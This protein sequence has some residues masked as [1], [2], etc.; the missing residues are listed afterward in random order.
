MKNWNKEMKSEFGTIHQNSEELL[1]RIHGNSGFPNSNDEELNYICHL[2]RSQVSL[3]LKVEELMLAKKEAEKNASEKYAELFQ[4]APVAYLTL[5]R[6]GKIIELNT[7]ASHLL[8]IECTPLR[9]IHFESFVDDDTKP[10]FNQ[11]LHRVLN[12]NSIEV[13]EVTILKKGSLPQFIRLT[14]K[15]S[16]NA[17]QYL[18]TAINIAELKRADEALIEADWRF[19]ALFENSPIAV[20]YH[21]MIYD[22]YRK[23]VDYRFLDANKSYRELTGTDPRG[24]TVKQAFPDIENGVFDW[25]GT[26]G[27]VVNTGKTIRF[28]Q[29]LQY[30][31]R[32]YDCVAYTYKPNHFVTSFLEITKR[33]SAEVALKESELK[34]RTVADQTSDWVYWIGEDQQIFYMSPAC[35]KITG[36]DPE[37]FLSKPQL[38]KEIVYSGDYDSI[39][40]YKNQ[41]LLKENRDKVYDLEIRVVSKEGALVW[42]HHI[43]S[44]IFNENGKYLGR[45]IS[46]RDITEK[47]K[48]ITDL[49]KAKERAEESDR[50]MSSFLANMSHEIRTPMTGI[51]GFTELLKE[52]NL[53]VKEQME[54]IRIIE[55]SGTRMLNII[56]DIMSISKVESG[57]MEVYLSE[58]NINTQIDY[59]YTFFKPEAEK[60][61][62]QLFFKKTLS[63]QEAILKTDKEKIYSILTNLVKNAIKF[64]PS[65]SIEFGYEKK[66]KYLEFFIKDTGPGI[67][68]EHKHFIFERF[69]QG[70]ESL[71][72][73]Y[74]GAGLGLTISKA[75]VEMLGGKIWV[76]STVGKGSIFYFTIPYIAQIEE[77]KLSKSSVSADNCIKKLKI[78]IAE[79]NQISSI[80]LGKVMGNFSKEVLNVNNGIDAV[81]VCFSNPDIDL[82]LMDIQMPLMD[83]YEA[84]RLIRKFNAEVVIIAQSAFALTGDQERAIAAG[85]N[86]YISKPIQQKHLTELISAY[87]KQPVPLI[88]N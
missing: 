2:E 61:G 47:K 14:G 81:E 9:D 28:E 41:I 24:K 43:S 65:G 70:S 10:L 72:R 32:W 82:V 86:S 85:C 34:F 27:K 5:S 33:K 20:A 68:E 23:P 48:M 16:A 11:F 59:L 76:E 25:I 80:L 26:Y 36:Y 57:Q 1:T 64:T 19:C 75:F 29:F 67:R 87:F 88:L 21:E 7:F 50:L 6:E 54:F 83:G 69:R 3:Q 79:D 8:G 73:N 63:S 77:K 42:I 35:K 55:I 45:R 39:L 22:E 62:L 18:L 31:N 53:S 78:L 37:E 30:N 58:T 44:P 15:A 60:K 74:E 17:D 38:I 13:C 56:N 12:N 84:T 51:L 40:N 52:P 4:L 46:N 66:D 49:I 71:S